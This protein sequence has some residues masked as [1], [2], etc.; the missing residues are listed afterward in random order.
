M[1]HWDL[2][3]VMNE[4]LLRPLHN[5]LDAF[6]L[7]HYNILLHHPRLHPGYKHRLWNL[8]D[9]WNFHCSLGLPDVAM[10]Q[11]KVTL[12]PDIDARS[13]HDPLDSGDGHWNFHDLLAH[14]THL[15]EDRIQN[16]PD[17][18]LGYLHSFLFNHLFWQQTNILYPMHLRYFYPSLNLLQLHSWNLVANGVVVNLWN[19]N[20]NVLLLDDTALYHLVKPFAAWWQRWNGKVQWLAMP[21]YI[22]LPLFSTPLELFTPEV[23]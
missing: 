17:G 13:L 2:H 15:F 21:A 12:L 7:R 14:L 5:F 18:D 9:M 4:L 3:T 6:N 20:H 8:K 23:F 19:F 16:F 22:R 10:A 1:N 11:H